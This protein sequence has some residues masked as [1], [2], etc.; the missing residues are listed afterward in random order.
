MRNGNATE[1]NTYM[2]RTIAALAVPSDIAV[3]VTVGARIDPRRPQILQLD[4]LSAKNLN[5][6]SVTPHTKTR[7]K[8]QSQKTIRHDLPTF[9]ESKK[10]LQLDLLS[11][12][13]N[14][15]HLR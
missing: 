7:S 1:T 14:L 6:E 9:A 4:L 11:A 8:V 2:T 15:S 12:K 5:V 3:A 13:K 10:I